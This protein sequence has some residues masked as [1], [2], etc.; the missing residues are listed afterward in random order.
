MRASFGPEGCHCYACLRAQESPHGM[1]WTSMI[2][3]LCTECGNK[4]CPKA[5]DH[6]LA[7]TGSNEPGQTGSRYTVSAGAGT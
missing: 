2:M 1:P 7:C 3:S 5:T 6:S 4:R